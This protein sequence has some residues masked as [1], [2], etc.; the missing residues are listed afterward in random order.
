MTRNSVVDVVS[1]KEMKPKPMSRE[2]NRSLSCV[3]TTFHSFIEITERAEDE[4]YSDIDH[5][6]RARRTA[7]ENRRGE[8]MPQI[9]PKN[10]RNQAGTFS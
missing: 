2:F 5:L 8:S 6:D 9:S 3:I 1:L 4:S 10:I 7:K